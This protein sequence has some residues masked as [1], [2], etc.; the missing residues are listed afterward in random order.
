MA[1]V[2]P[3]DVLRYWITSKPQIAAKSPTGFADSG[4]VGPKVN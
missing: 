3:V 1:V 2:A 4:L